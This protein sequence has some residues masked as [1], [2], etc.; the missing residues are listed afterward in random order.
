M[1][2]ILILSLLSTFF[3]EKS[4]SKM[5]QIWDSLTYY[6]KWFI[7]SLM[8]VILLLL[9]VF[10][11]WK[12]NFDITLISII[13]T[14]IYLSTSLLYYYFLTNAINK[15]DRSTMSLLSV[16]II[17]MLL[18]TDILLWYNVN[19][20]HIIGVIFMLIII[21][22]S[23]WNGSINTKWIFWIIWLQLILTIWVTIYKYMITYYSSVEA[24]SIID[25]FITMVFFLWVIVIKLWFNWVKQCFEYNN[26]KIW[27]N[28]SIWEIIALFSYLFWP[29]S[30][31]T[32]I[33]QIFR[34]F[35]WIVFGKYLF[36]E[37]NFWKKIW[38]LAVLS[39]GVVIMNLQAFTVHANFL[40]N[41]NLSLFKWDIHWYRTHLEETIY[42]DDFSSNFKFSS[43]PYYI[44]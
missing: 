11:V 43:L 15:S 35:W 7:L 29:A 21:I 42:I 19:M 40:S 6:Q 26:I 5:K 39:I 44:E 27:I 32:A 31:V 38:N 8:I 30:I 41:I 36:N 10:T 37:E 12:W 18:I 24:I 4:Y 2:N 16:L 13:L 33:R 25:A 14:I 28:S 34:M 17:P 23:S 1:I 3:E 9:I 22:Y 20:Y